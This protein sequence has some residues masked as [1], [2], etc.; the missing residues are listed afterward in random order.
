MQLS[1]GE[2]LVLVLREVRHP[3]ARSH[4][5]PKALEIITSRK[6]SFLLFF[7]I[8]LSARCATSPRCGTP[9]AG[10]QVK[11]F[12]NCG[13][14]TIFHSNSYLICKKDSHEAIFYWIEYFDTGAGW[15]F[16]LLSFFGKGKAGKSRG[17]NQ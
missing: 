10:G 2:L 13:M 11:K 15:C 9:A 12:P 8:P 3:M 4:R 1:P 16:I 14:V 5:M 17:P 6:T 7:F